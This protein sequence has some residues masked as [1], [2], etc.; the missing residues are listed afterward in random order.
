LIR[1]G[2]DIIVDRDSI[3]KI[4]IGKHGE[5]LKLVGTLA[6]KEI[7]E[8]VHKK[9]YLELYVKTIKNWREKE[10]FLKEFGFHEFGS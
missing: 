2:V 8:M 3:K 1:I 6:R 10:K 4:V 5:R 9:V 7:E